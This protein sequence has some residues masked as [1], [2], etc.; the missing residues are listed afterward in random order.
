M[1]QLLPRNGADVTVACS[2]KKLRS[3]PERLPFLFKARDE[4]CLTQLSDLQYVLDV[5]AIRRAVPLR[6]QIPHRVRRVAQ[7]RLHGVEVQARTCG[8]ENEV[9]LESL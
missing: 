9:G 2:R 4:E 1:V 7:N 5:W 8:E 6:V 3:N